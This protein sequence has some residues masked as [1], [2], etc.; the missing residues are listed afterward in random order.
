MEER[1]DWLL[2]VLARLLVGVASAFLAAMA[3]HVFVD[4]ALKNLFNAPIPATDE[5]VGRYYMIGVVFLPLP[6]VETRNAAVSVDLLYDRAGLTARRLML[7]LAYAGQ[8]ILF[9]LL[10][11]QSSIDAAKSFAIREYVSSQI[12]LTVWPASFLLPIG[13]SIAGLVSI[14]RLYQIV[15]RPD[16]ERVCSYAAAEDPK[17][18][19]R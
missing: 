9:G 17:G 3:V 13:F 18:Y 5:V 19:S 15:T 16:W 4:V 2:G 7:L 6:F 12:V 1:I 8:T 11:C 14:L 10:A